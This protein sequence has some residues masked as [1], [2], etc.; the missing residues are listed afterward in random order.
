MVRLSSALL[1]VMLLVLAA[2]GTTLLVPSQYGTIQ[3]GIDAASNGD[4]VL[5]ADG[6]YTGTGNKDLDFGGRIIVVMSENGPD[7]CII[8]CE[9]DG[10]GF[11]FHSGE[12]ADAVIYG[13][14]IR[15]GY[16]SNGGGINV[17]DS[18]PTIDHCIVWDCANGGTAGGG[19]YLNNGHSL[20]VHC[21]VNDNFS[22]HGGG[23]YAINSNMT[24]SSCII[25]DNYS[26]G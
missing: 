25:S 21:T 3:A 10:R 22:G 6:T 18:S 16:A 26:T 15:Y 17:T 20:I 9:N 4:T 1:A 12:T 23:I 8:D 13:F 19:I 7:V 2:S 24:V 5:V 11:Y 14:M